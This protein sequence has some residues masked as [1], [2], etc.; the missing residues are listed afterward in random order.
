MWISHGLEPEGVTVLGGHKYHCEGRID[1]TGQQWYAQRSNNYWK[2]WVWEDGVRT[3]KEKFRHKRD[4]LESMA[5]QT[6][7]EV[8]PWA[9]E[10][11]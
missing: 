4:M 7:E 5:T 3:Y 1:A 6:Y 10:Q 2:L 9:V 8:F 11:R